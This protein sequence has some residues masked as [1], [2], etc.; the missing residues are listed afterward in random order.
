[1]RGDSPGPRV[2][3]RP[4]IEISIKIRNNMGLAKCSPHAHLLF[5]PGPV[6]ALVL[7]FLSKP[8]Y[9]SHEEFNT[10]ED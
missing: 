6:L 4:R 3:P 10:A 2:F 7:N 9:Q 5:T 8:H 1:M